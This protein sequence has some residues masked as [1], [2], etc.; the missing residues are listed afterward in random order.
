ML[1]LTFYTVKTWKERGLIW[2]K[3]NFDHTYF[4]KKKIDLT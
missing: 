3:I 1:T 2:D 4:I